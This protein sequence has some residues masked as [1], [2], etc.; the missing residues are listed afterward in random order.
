MARTSKLKAHVTLDMKGAACP[1][2][3]LGARR[4]L[5]DLLPGE[6]L[7]LVS[8]CPA[9]RDDLYSWPKYADVEILKSEKQARGATRYYIR[10]GKGRRVSPNTVLDMRGATCPGPVLEARKLLMRMKSGEVL[11]LVSD[12]PGIRADVRSWVKATGLELA[13]A[14]ERAPGEFEFHIRKR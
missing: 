14:R 7:L 2:P 6:V 3:L 13:D 5:D 9:T 12:C 11:Q 1:G 4:V 8:D 10:K